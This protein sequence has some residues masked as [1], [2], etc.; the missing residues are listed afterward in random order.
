MHYSRNKK[1]II[2]KDDIF[3]RQNYNDLGLLQVVLPGQTIK[4]LLQSLHRTAGKH[5]D[6]SKKM[7]ELQQKFRFPS[8]ATYIKNWFR[9]CE[10]CI[11]DTG[12]NNTRIA[13]DLIHI[14]ERDLGPEDLMQI[15]LLPKLPEVTIISI[16][17]LMYFRGMQ[18]L[19][20]FPTP[21][22]QIQRKSL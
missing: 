5:P 10:I 14:P 19:I 15:D 11:Q 3:C 22:K 17:Q 7:P 8:I 1:L 2:I 21:R 9:D 12:L 18:L 13:S 4:V 16:R 6:I 20:Q